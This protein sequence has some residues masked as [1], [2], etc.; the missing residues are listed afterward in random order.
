MQAGLDTPPQQ[1]CCQPRLVVQLL[2]DRGDQ[3]AAP[4]DMT[5]AALLA[6]QRGQP[7]ALERLTQPPQAFAADTKGS[8]NLAG[9]PT[10]AQQRRQHAVAPQRGLGA[11]SER[12]ECLAPL[13]GGGGVLLCVVC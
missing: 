2:L 13:W 10:F 12:R 9:R 1:R 11:A 3:R 4:R 6:T 5:A 8:C 7:V